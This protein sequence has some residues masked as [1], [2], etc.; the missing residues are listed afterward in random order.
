MDKISKRQWWLYALY[1]LLFLIIPF[2]TSPDFSWDF[3]FIRVSGFKES[4]LSYFL[5]LVFFFL[6]S[7]VLLPKFYFQRKMWQFWSIIV[8]CFL[9]YSFIPMQ[10]FPHF[11]RGSHFAH[12]FPGAAGKM[13]PPIMRPP[14][15]HSPIGF[16]ITRYVT[17]FALVGLF[18]YSIASNLRWKQT[19]KARVEAEISYL[20]AQINPH[21]LFNSL[22]SIY[23]LAIDKSDETADA[24]VRLSGLMRYVLTDASQDHVPLHREIDYISNYISLQEIRITEQTKFSFSV[25]GNPGANIS[26]DADDTVY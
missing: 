22:N 11:V 19:E 13:M 12:Q 15:H 17:Q 23:A 24:V 7:F 14:R 20:K 26:P 18:S 2:F 8:V 4:F 3:S 21:F 25:D 1:S 10:I 9:I 16:I 6:N 5:L